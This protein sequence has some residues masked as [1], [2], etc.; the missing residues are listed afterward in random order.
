MKRKSSDGDSNVYM[1]QNI[2]E[3]GRTCETPHTGLIYEGRR[4]HA[5]D[6]LVIWQLAGHV[7]H[8]YS[9]QHFSGL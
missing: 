6:R 8:G 7:P 5:V 4:Q 2:Y 9:G 3:Q 1:K